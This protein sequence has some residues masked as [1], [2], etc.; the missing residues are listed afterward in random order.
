[1]PNL[2]YLAVENASWQIW[3]LIVTVLHAMACIF[4]QF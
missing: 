4:R 1:M 2:T 3:L